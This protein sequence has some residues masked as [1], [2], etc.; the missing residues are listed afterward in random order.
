MKVMCILID[1]VYVLYAQWLYD[2]RIRWDQVISTE[3]ILVQKITGD[4]NAVEDIYLISFRVTQLCL[5]L[6]WLIAFYIT[7]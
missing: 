3:W 1:S 6:K 7:G 5:N 4:L 2:Y